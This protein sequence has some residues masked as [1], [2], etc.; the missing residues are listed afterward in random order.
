MS[1][2]D[3][4][5]FTKVMDPYHQMALILCIF[6]GVLLLAKIVE[7]LNLTTLD[8]DLPWT[9]A[10]TFLLFYAIFNS[11]FSLSATND[12]AY[13]TKSFISFLGFAIVSGAAAY[14]LAGLAIT[15][16]GPYKWIYIVITFVYLVFISI[17]GFMKKIVGF[18]QREE[19]T[20]PMRRSKKR[21]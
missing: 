15:D 13:W 20:K 1:N 12:N 7:A 17:I 3:N 21:N 5:I 18:A 16:I 10:A 4:S 14:V 6:G 8:A 9:I 11:V 2:A 19:W